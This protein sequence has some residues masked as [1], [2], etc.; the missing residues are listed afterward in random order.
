[1]GVLGEGNLYFRFFPPDLSIVES[2]D[3]T[4]KCQ[5]ES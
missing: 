3:N 5:A 1:M 2:I 4:N